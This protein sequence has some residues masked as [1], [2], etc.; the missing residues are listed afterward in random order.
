MDITYDKEADAI[1]IRLIKGKLFETRKE[2]VCLIDYS[3]GGKILG[4]E[5]INWS[6]VFSNA[7]KLGA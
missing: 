6:R 7:T 1:Y 4:I 5:I 2:G 3:K